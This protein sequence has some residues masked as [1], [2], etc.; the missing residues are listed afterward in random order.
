MNRIDM[1]TE[2]FKLKYDKFMVGCDAIEEEGKW[3]KETNGEMEGFYQNDL[4]SVIIRLIAVDGMVSGKETEYLN[5][6]FGFDY[7]SEELAQVYIYC[8]EN[9]DRSFDETFREGIELMRS[10]SEKLA[11]AYRELLC[12]ICDI[13]IECDEDIA[14]EEIEEAKNLKELFSK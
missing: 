13:I 7:S 2:E 6:N 9:I 12:L 8:K 11:E 4:V 1:L 3:D 10:V 14:P 5:K